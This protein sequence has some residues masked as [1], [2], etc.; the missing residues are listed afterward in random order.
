VTITVVAGSNHPPAQVTIEVMNPEPVIRPDGPLFLRGSA[1][2]P[3][4]DSPLTFRWS[5]GIGSGGIGSGGDLEPIGEGETLPDWSPQA[6]YDPPEAGDTLTILLEV[7]D[8]YGGA[9]SASVDLLV[10]DVPVEPTNEAPYPTIVSPSSGA[11]LAADTATTL[12]GSV[13]DPEGDSPIERY[14]HANVDGTS[15]WTELGTGGTLPWTPA[16]WLDLPTGAFAATVN[17]ALTAIDPHGA[18]RGA[19]V[20]VVVERVASVQNSAPDPV[21]ILSPSNGAVVDADDRLTLMGSATDPDGDSPLTY[22]WW[23]QLSGSPFA[24]VIG[25]GPALQWVPSDTFAFSEDGFQ[26]TATVFFSAT[27]PYGAEG[28]TAVQITVVRVQ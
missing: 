9:A 25:S 20:Q 16:E 3:D 21:A 11:T 26:R 8:A 13:Y 19:V 18:A 24:T 7:T 10:E 1:V 2:D 12:V 4:G 28:S 14:W 27:D 22:R 15:V 23:A 5:A 6:L 17:L